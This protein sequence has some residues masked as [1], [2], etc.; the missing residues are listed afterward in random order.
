VGAGLA[1]IGGW[2]AGYW[3]Q[4]AA[5]ASL[6][7]AGSL[8]VETPAASARRVDLAGAAFFGSAMACLIAGLTLGRQD[9]GRVATVGTL[10]GSVVLL[11]GFIYIERRRAEPMIDLALF[12]RP[13]F[14]ASASGAL[15]VGLAV[16]A[17][18][19]FLPT[20]L[21]RA[22][23]HSTLASAWILAL[24]SVTGTI[25]AFQVR[26]LPDRL[27]SG[28]RVAL[29]FVCGAIG[30]TTISDVSAHS[31]WMRLAPGLILLGAG[32]G[33]TNAALGRLAVESVPR[34]RAGMGSGASNTA[35]YLGG[36][37]G[38]APWARGHVAGV[39]CPRN[40]CS[41]G[42]VHLNAVPCGK[43]VRAPKVST[44]NELLPAG[45]Q[46]GHERLLRPGIGGLHGCA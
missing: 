12:R 5:A 45:G 39:S 28:H 10:V 43:P 16:V 41:A 29:G 35:R 20:F 13:M 37:A 34:A 38:V 30:L 36:A 18:V 7:P 24:F 1:L 14:L 6:I 19:S 42:A 23:H 2:R 31:S 4:A 9:W 32:Y 27:D 46:P 40:V 8:L 11:V 15:F 22:L 44:V 17:V 25:V 21:Q 3:F 26:R 33:L